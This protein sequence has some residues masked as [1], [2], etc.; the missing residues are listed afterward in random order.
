MLGIKSLGKL[1]SQVIGA[2]DV[3]LEKT[4]L[5]FISRL[6]LFD[7]ID[8]SWPLRLVREASNDASPS[9]SSIYNLFLFT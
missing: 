2:F 7:G 1:H 6:D 3:A 8:V 4:M 5:V 9:F